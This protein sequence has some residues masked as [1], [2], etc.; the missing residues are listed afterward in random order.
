MID[1]RKLQRITPIKVD[2]EKQLYAEIEML[3]QR[4]TGQ[5]ALAAARAQEIKTL[6]V[7]LN[8]FAMMLEN[9]DKAEGCDND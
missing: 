1:I 2:K 9:T 8:C 4:L 7:R 5:T 6:K 3:K